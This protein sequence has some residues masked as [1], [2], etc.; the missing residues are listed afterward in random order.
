M[1]LSPDEREVLDAIEKRL[2]AE[3]PAF[4][5][6]LSFGTENRYRSRHTVLAHG[7]LWLGIVLTLTGFCLVHPAPAA[8]VMLILYGGGILVLAL[9]RLLSFRPPTST[10]RRPRLL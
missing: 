6:K 10:G 9:V 3:D 5:A 7:C 4:P 8:G 1:P 2:L